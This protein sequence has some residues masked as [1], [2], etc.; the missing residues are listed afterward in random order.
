M[1]ALLLFS[2][3]W[4]S[5]GFSDQHFVSS[6]LLGLYILSLSDLLVMF[7]VRFRDFRH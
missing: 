6:A 4:L 1:V 3:L 5:F 7:N 2:Q